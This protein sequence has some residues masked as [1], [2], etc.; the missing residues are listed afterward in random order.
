MSSGTQRRDVGLTVPE[1]LKQQLL[2]AAAARDLSTGDWV[3]A[4]AAAHGPALRDALRP[5]EVRRRPKVDGAAFAVLQLTSEERDH[6]D[7]LAVACGLNRSVF[8]TSVSRLALGEELE[9]VLAP[10]V[11]PG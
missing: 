9:V 11:E 8:V 1:A 6:L 2:A 3:L 10:M 7:D 4:A 5:L